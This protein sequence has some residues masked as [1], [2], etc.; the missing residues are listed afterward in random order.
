MN[1]KANEIIGNQM[2]KTFLRMRNRIVWSP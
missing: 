2:D 1:N